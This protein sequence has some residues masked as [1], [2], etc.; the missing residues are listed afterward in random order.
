LLKER[1]KKEPDNNSQQA[2]AVQCAVHAALF[3]AS[4]LPRDHLPLHYKNVTS[5]RLLA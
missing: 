2:Q 1:K 5:I 3:P 4:S